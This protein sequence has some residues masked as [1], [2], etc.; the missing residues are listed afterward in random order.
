ML[1]FDKTSRESF[2]H[3]PDWLDE[4]NKFSET[5]SRVIVGNKQDSKEM[6]QVD[7]E[8]G[9]KFAE[10]RNMHYIET[11]AMNGNQV[12]LAFE[13][14]AR[15]LISKKTVNQQKGN[16]IVITKGKKDFGC[17]QKI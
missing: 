7:E 12:S 11:S 5:S 14:M 16:K 2:D 1:V 3:I 17:C 8:T 6:I 15:D 13:I 4:I 9:K 10:N